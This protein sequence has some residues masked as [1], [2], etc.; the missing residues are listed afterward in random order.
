MDIELAANTTIDKPLV[1]KT[2]DMKCVQNSN[3]ILT[4][5]IVIAI[6]TIMKLI[7]KIIF[8]NKIKL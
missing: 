4:E 7:I 8:D 5:E 3:K 6:L 1:K 2:L